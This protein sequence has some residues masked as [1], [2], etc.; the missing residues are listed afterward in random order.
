M[1]RVRDSNC[2]FCQ[3]KITPSKDQFLDYS[4]IENSKIL[5]YSNI[6]SRQQTKNC[7]KHHKAMVKLIKTYRIM[8]LLP[9]KSSGIGV[10]QLFS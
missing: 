10:A 2:F 5:N 7:T 6:R 3:K 1:A 9:N 4:V 8:G